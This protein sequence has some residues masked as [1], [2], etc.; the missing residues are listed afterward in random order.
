MAEAHIRPD[1]QS[2]LMLPRRSSAL[3][4]WPGTKRRNKNQNTYPIQRGS[5]KNNV[6][7]DM[8]SSIHSQAKPAPSSWTTHPS[9]PPSR[10]HRFSRRQ[11]LKHPCVRRPFPRRPKR[12]RK[13]KRTG[14][15]T[16][17]DARKEANSLIATM[18][19]I[20][21]LSWIFH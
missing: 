16:L 20:D 19:S 6:S 7:N 18:K 4:L 17:V 11:A 3:G 8:S 10:R 2:K 1:D 14:H 21:K 12:K 9:Q 15:G 5:R 13:R